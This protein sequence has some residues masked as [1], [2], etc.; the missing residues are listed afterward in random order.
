MAYER[1]MNNFLNCLPF[2][3]LED[4]L[5]N[6]V[7]LDSAFLKNA[8]IDTQCR[9]ANLVAAGHLRDALRIRSKRTWLVTQN[10]YGSVVTDHV[11]FPD[12][13][14]Y[15]GNEADFD[16]YMHTDPRTTKQSI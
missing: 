15:T 13:G 7:H 9:R 3:N 8:N 10:C 16:A 4:V 12:A 5:R 14:T 1:R 2:I 11:S 6:R